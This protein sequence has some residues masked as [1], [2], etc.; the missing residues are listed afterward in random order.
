MI[1]DTTGVTLD[2]EIRMEMVSQGFMTADNFLLV[3]KNPEKY[4]YT[5]HE[6]EE[7]PFEH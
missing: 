4:Q 6:N 1:K 5:L 3:L 2:K 7:I